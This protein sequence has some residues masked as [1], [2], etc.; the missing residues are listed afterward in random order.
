[1][2][3][4]LRNILLAAALFA[5]LLSPS[6]FN[7]S[8]RWA[9][10]LK[11]E[12]IATLELVVVPSTEQERYRLFAPEEYAEPVKL[13][14][15]SCGIYTLF[16]IPKSGNSHALYV[17]LTDGTRHCVVNSSSGYLTIDGDVYYYPHYERVLDW[18]EA[19]DLALGNAKTP[20]G[21]WERN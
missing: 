21:F 10:S 11:A 16:P 15:G 9:R 19:H 13:I 17:T 18:I 4:K 1:M 8:I 7:S 14:N 2:N 3:R 12:D 5:L 20:D 6:L